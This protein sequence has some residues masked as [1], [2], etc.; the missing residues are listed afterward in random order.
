MEKT[1]YFDFING[2]PENATVVLRNGEEL[3]KSK[4][5]VQFE[6]FTGDDAKKTFMSGCEFVIRFGRVN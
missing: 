4:F 1:T 5:L 6:S 2:L 3:S